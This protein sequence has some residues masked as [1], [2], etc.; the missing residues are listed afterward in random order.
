MGA[1]WGCGCEEGAAQT[2]PQTAR[3]RP[4]HASPYLRLALPLLP[5]HR[6]V[7]RHGQRKVNVHC[8][9]ARQRRRVAAA[10][11]AA[12]RGKSSAAVAALNTPHACLAHCTRSLPSCQLPKSQSPSPPRTPSRE[13]VVARD[14]PHEGHG[15][16][17]V[18]VDA[19]RHH[20]LAARVQ[21][22][23]AGGR[24]LKG[25]RASGGRGRAVA[26]SQRQAH[27][28]RGRA[29]AVGRRTPAGPVPLSR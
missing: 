18:R 26:G 8:G 22:P 2:L 14:L 17:G 23:R 27:M 25:R 3:A 28:W 4:C 15:Q 9:A 6:H 11:A 5:A 10:V 21:H 12:V 7:V 13:E 24:L 1:R 29:L 19:A 16:V 20:Q